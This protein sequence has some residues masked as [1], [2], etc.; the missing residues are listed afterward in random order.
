MRLKIDELNNKYGKLTVISESNGRRHGQVYWNCICDCGNKTTVIGS[1]LRSG[2]TKSCGCLIKEKIDEVGNRY[3]RLLV[4]SEADKR[5]KYNKIQWNC[6]CDCGKEAIVS[7]NNMRRG[8]TRSCGCLQLEKV[9]LKK[10]EAAFNHLFLQHKGRARR[11]S[12]EFTLSKE[13]FR[14]L[15]SGNCIYCGVEPRYIKSKGGKKDLYG[16]YVYNGID[17]VDNGLGYIL[18]NCVTCCGRCNSMKE[19]MDQDNFIAHI[20]MVY[21]YQSNL[22]LQE[23][24]LHE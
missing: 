18:D 2:H 3:G 8:T 9:R 24:I 16:S 17:R 10:G 7:G 5:T 22:Q 11:K 13:R 6:L 20:V 21:K 1:D 12:M 19:M 4:I 15:T 23:K 14:K